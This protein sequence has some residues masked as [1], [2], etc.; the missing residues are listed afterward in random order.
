[1]FCDCGSLLLIHTFTTYITCS[2]CNT[3]HNRNTI[4]PICIEKHY[5]K[6]VKRQINKP[7]QAK[8]KH[9]CLKCGADEMY[10]YALQTRS[11]DE[12]QTIFYVCECKYTERV[13]S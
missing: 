8:I 13:Y 2:S 12:G 11:V 7:T 4:K 5:T 10:Y 9:K 3:T 6:T 1:M